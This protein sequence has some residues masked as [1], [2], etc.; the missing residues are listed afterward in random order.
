[1]AGG[2]KAGKDHG[3]IEPGNGT[4]ITCHLGQPGDETF[5]ELI[6][7]RVLRLIQLL[8]R[9]SRVEDLPERLLDQ[10]MHGL[11]GVRSILVDIL[12]QPVGVPD[13][14]LVENGLVLFGDQGV[15]LAHALE[16]LLLVLAFLV[17]V[18]DDF[19]ILRRR[20]DSCRPLLLRLELLGRSLRGHPGHWKR[21]YQRES[22]KEKSVAPFHGLDPSITELNRSR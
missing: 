14:R 4:R 10:L 21:R 1:M 11:A 6:L 13:R 9:I 12:R 22:K 8:A 19:Q 5:L 17:P 18:L 2:G 20:A 15:T 16:F 3:G 7:E